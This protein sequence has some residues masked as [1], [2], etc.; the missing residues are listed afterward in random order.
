MQRLRPLSSFSFSSPRLLLR[1]K[2]SNFIVG[3]ADTCLIQIEPHCIFFK[4]SLFTGA[5]RY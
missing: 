4:Y 1:K 3:H 5:N 2:Q